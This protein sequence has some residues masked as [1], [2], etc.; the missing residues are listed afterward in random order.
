M[1]LFPLRRLDE[2]CEVSAGDPA[3]QEPSAFAADG[4]PFVRM[5]DVGR[6]HHSISLSETVDRISGASQAGRRLRRFPAG[7]LLIPKSGASINLNH[8]ALLGVEAHVV[9]HL[10]VLVPCHDVILP[11]YLFYWSL[12]Y[13]PREQAQTTSLPSLPL[14]LIRAAPV[15]VP[16]LDEQRRIVDLLSRAASLK[17][18]AEEAQA[19]ARELIPALFV[20]M[21]GDPAM[22]PK[23]WPKV[24]LGDLGVRFVGGKNLKA[25]PENGSVY[26]ILKI[27]AVTSGTFNP[28]EAKPAPSNYLPPAEHFVR[29]GDILFSRANTAELVGATAKVHEPPANLLLPDKLWRVDLP[30]GCQCS[31]DFL[32]RTLQQRATRAELSKMATGTSDSMRNISQG[33]LKTLSIMCPPLPLQKEFETRVDEIASVQRLSEQAAATAEATNAALMSRLFAT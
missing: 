31:K 15:P 8:R 20:D 12:S 5:Q 3:P 29:T 7:S 2:L 14:S 6:A 30:E 18:L 22:N 17:R 21:F 16:P 24:A 10:A 25:G 19:K 4:A 23:T 28:R 32:F 1:S 33:R 27:S 9:S 11:E 26:R 13:D